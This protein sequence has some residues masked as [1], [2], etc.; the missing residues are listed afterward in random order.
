M[1]MMH[2]A[3]MKIVSQTFLPSLCPGSWF[4]AAYCRSYAHFFF[5]WLILRHIVLYVD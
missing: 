4:C 3:N 2:G 5:L 1:W